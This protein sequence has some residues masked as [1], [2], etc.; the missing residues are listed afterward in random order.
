MIYLLT[1][2]GCILP[3]LTT[4][5]EEEPQ[6]GS[7][8]ARKIEL[9]HK[10]N[11]EEAVRRL[12]SAD[13]RK[14]AW[15]YL[16]SWLELRCNTEREWLMREKI[17]GA[18][19]KWCT[20]PGTCER[21]RLAG[22]EAMRPLC[23]H[24]RRRDG[25]DPEVCRRIRI[26]ERWDDPAARAQSGRSWQNWVLSIGSGAAIAGAGLG[27]FIWKADEA[28]NSADRVA[29]AETPEECGGRQTSACT[30]YFEDLRD[31][32]R[33]WYALAA[34]SVVSGSLVTWFLLDDIEPNPPV[35]IG[36]TPNSLQLIITF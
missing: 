7:G 10:D 12:V 28:S 33:L 24:Q 22:L 29:K 1:A 32:A 31:E 25:S 17:H 5:G 16:Q 20:R 14:E 21:Y 6:C 8:E 35:A 2:L 15:H 11:Q 3:P 13:C 36:A 30:D 27:F 4:A 18:L 23:E 19:V 9:E 26:L 34:A